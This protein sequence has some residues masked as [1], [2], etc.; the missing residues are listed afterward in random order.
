MI[1]GSA[2]ERTARAAFW[3][4][5]APLKQAWAAVL[6]AMAAPETPL[7][8]SV[9]PAAL[10]SELTAPEHTM[11]ERPGGAKQARTV[12]PQALDADFGLS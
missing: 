2:F 7:W 3:R 8:S 6:S 1:S 5:L 11:N 12:L 9:A 4:A 10:S